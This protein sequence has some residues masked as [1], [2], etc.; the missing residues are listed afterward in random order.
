MTYSNSLLTDKITKD[1]I[2]ILFNLFKNHPIHDIHSLYKAETGIS[3]VTDDLQKIYIA[4]APDKQYS[5]GSQL[6]TVRKL[7]IWKSIEQRI[8]DHVNEEIADFIYHHWKQYQN[9]NK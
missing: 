2:K 9:K 6:T 8:R 7:E 5:F 3:I 1:K 4:W